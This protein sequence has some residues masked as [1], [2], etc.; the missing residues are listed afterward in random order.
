MGCGVEP[1]LWRGARIHQN[2]RPVGHEAFESGMGCAR[3]RAAPCVGLRQQHVDQPVFALTAAIEQ[4]QSTVVVTQHAQEGCG[5]ING[6]QQEGRDIGF[7]CQQGTAHIHKIA[8]NRFLNL[9]VAGNMAAIGTDL[10]VDGAFENS[11]SLTDC[12]IIVAQRRARRDQALGRS[13]QAGPL[14]AAGQRPGRDA[15]TDGRWWR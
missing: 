14:D 15:W 11:Q 6:C 9:W 13:D 1:G 4:R 3:R 10:S 2:N 12:T 5:A 8:Q 7:R